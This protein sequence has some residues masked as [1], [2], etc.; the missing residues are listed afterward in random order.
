MAPIYALATHTMPSDYG[1]WVTGPLRAGVGAALGRRKSERWTNHR[2]NFPRKISWTKL[3]YT[4]DPFACPSTML[5]LNASTWYPRVFPPFFCCSFVFSDDCVC[6]CVLLT[7][8]RRHR[9][10]THSTAIFQ[11]MF[12]NGFFSGWCKRPTH[13]Q[14]PNG[15]PSSQ[16]G[17]ARQ[18]RL[19]EFHN[20][21]DFRLPLFEGRVYPGANFPAILRLWSGP[22]RCAHYWCYGHLRKLTIL[23]GS[24]ARSCWAFLVWKIN[25][26][27]KFC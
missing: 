15:S 27:R 7:C 2:I 6:V 25:E 12:F 24:C 13:I 1:F 17:K 4:A 5:F 21:L 16:V 19:E 8:L 9:H 26:I 11:R 14:N 3:G 18:Q 22:R 10:R 20:E 23:S